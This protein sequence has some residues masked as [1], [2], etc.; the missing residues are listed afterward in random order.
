LTDFI[1]YAPLATGFF[2]V[3]AFVKL[4]K[5]GSGLFK[6]LQRLTKQV[7]P[8]QKLQIAAE[9]PAPEFEPST[10]QDARRNRK[11]YLAAKAKRK[12]DKQRRLVKNLRE[13][14]KS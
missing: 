10:E 11:R 5:A 6:Q 12:A 4:A 7:E 3:F 1:W 9:E 13:L 14:T 8:L 2:I